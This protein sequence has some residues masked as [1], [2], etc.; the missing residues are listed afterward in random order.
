MIERHVNG[1]RIMF[2]ARED[3][4]SKLVSAEYSPTEAFLVKINLRNGYLVAL[5]IEIEMKL[6]FTLI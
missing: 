2:F 3:I 1:R 4:P 6:G 5:T